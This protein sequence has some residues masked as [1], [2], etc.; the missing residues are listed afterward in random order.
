MP[1]RALHDFR[2]RYAEH[3]HRAWAEHY[4]NI[5]VVLDAVATNA[6]PDR[7][8]R[9]NGGRLRR[10][11]TSAYDEAL[12]R[13]QPDDVVE[14]A[15]AAG[16]WSRAGEDRGGEPPSPALAL[17][18]SEAVRALVFVEGRCTQLEKSVAA[19]THEL[20]ALALAERTAKV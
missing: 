20:D 17:L 7:P 9:P 14:P 18:R 3:Q 6:A 15:G 4:V 16:G 10:L 5:N 19:L 11:P 1:R 12:A 13:S 8:A 2:L